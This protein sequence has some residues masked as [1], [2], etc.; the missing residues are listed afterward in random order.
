MLFVKYLRAAVQSGEITTTVRVWRSPRVSV[1]KRYRMEGGEI[2]IDSIESITFD[3]ITPALARD[4]GFQGVADLLAL[5]RHGS[6]ENVY[7]I[8]F[9]Y[10]A[11]GSAD[12]S[13]T[14]S[15]T[16][17]AAERRRPDQSRTAPRTHRPGAKS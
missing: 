13:G 2:E 17:K 7:L 9:H 3:D 12:R 5:A 15:S 14:K 10:I 8:R 4:C 16:P 1:G 11:P 6:G